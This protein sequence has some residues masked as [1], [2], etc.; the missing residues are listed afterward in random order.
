VITEKVI[1]DLIYAVAKLN[2]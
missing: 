1:F 2:N